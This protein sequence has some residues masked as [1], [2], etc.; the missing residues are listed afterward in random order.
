MDAV[1]CYKDS[2]P[3]TWDKYLGP[4]AVALQSAINRHTGYTPN[5]L[6]LEREV[7]VPAT[8]M[9]GHPLKS[10]QNGE[11]GEINMYVQKL[12]QTVQKAHNAT[13]QKLK[14]AHKFMKTAQDIRLC[15]CPFRVGDFV[16][17]RRNAGKKVESSRE[18]SGVYLEGSRY[19][20]KGQVR[21]C[22][23]SKVMQRSS[24]HAS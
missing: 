11:E 23:H 21:Y 4:L 19:N 24:D 8:L 22:V 14:S 18:E 2:Q 10:F 12:E 1:C 13:K 9:Y 15:T 6:M 17:W 3:K 20:C 16:Y 5:R 7:N